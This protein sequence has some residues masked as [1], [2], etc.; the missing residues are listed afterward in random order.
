MFDSKNSNYR[1]RILL[2]AS[3]NHVW[4][5][6]F[7][8]LLVP[9][10][11]LMKEDPE[12]HF[13]FSEIGMLRTAHSMA[14][15]AFQIPFGL[16]AEKV[17]EYWLLLGGNFWVAASYLILASMSWFPLFLSV[18][19]IG[20][21][22]GGAQHPLAASWVSRVYEKTGILFFLLYIIYIFL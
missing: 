16:V 11:V 6:L 14:M 19:L 4:S 20:G 15:A 22:G 9:L 5:D 17:G 3:M 13:S 1:G 18:T 2:F 7:F 8:A 21:L 10:L 12:L